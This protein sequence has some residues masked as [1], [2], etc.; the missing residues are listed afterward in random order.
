[1]MIHISLLKGSLQGPKLFPVGFPWVLS[2]H[3]LSVVKPRFQGQLKRV[4][5]CGGVYPFQACCQ[6]VI[7]SDQGRLDM[8]QKMWG[9]QT[10]PEI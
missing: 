10:E 9:I 5:I 8:I 7:Y 1:M 6:S 2:P 3:Q 4:D